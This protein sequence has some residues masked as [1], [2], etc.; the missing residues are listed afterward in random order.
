MGFKKFK[1][2]NSTF[3]TNNCGEYILTEGGMGFKDFMYFN[4]T[5]LA[6]KMWRILTRPYSLVAIV[7]KEKYFEDSTV[8]CWIGLKC[9]TK[10]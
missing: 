7:M 10:T 8:F 2:F 1:C 3:L 6:K 5:L 9:P 4:S